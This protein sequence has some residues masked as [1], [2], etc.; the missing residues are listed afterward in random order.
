MIVP[1][2]G[3]MQ[4]RIARLVVGVVPF[5]IGKKVLPPIN[6]EFSGG[7]LTK[8]FLTRQLTVVFYCLAVKYDQKERRDD[9]V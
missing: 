3:T 6:A 2:G 7:H 1:P 8:R 4:V 9:A 5:T